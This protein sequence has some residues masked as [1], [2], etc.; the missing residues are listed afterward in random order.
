MQG[1]R[2]ERRRHL[3]HPSAAAAADGGPLDER[4]GAPARH[5]HLRPQGGGGGS[6]AQ[7][8]GGARRGTARHRLVRGGEFGCA[9]AAVRH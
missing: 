9:A 1:A 5:R 4:A 2:E 6:G 8:F 7:R 3:L